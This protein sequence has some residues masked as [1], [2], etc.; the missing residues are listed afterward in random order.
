[1]PP[2]AQQRLHATPAYWQAM[3]D[4]GGALH[5]HVQPELGADIKLW[6]RLSAIV[7]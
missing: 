3:H 5:D 2:S 6:Q 7:T 1:M 4:P